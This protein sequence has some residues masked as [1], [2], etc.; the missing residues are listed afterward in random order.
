MPDGD[1]VM[2]IEEV[3][4]Y[5][6]RIIDD[7][8]GDEWKDL[9]YYLGS[10][11]FGTLYYDL[12]EIPWDGSDKETMHAIHRN[13]GVAASMKQ[14]FGYMKR[15]FCDWVRDELGNIQYN[16]GG[17]LPN[18]LK[19]AYVAEV[20][21]RGDGFLN[22]NYTKTLEKVYGIE[23]AMICHVH[24]KVG[25]DYDDIFF[26][27]GDRS[28]VPETINSIGADLFLGDLKRDLRKDT[29][30]ALNRHRDFFNKVNTD[31]QTIHSFGFSFSDVDMIYIEE[32]ANRVDKNRAIWYL[33]NH[34]AN[35]KPDLKVKDWK[36]K[37]QKLEEIGFNV[38]VDNR[39]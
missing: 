6:T 15:L 5:L 21:N 23:P 24:G 13:E 32:I 9:E 17:L 22:F 3:A 28:G 2:D 38:Q 7:C 1:E 30:K 29:D 25:D 27:H 10:S 37:R 35:E 11:I 18:M 16:S 39:W 12:E 26:G 4:G 19:K 36:S 8:G 33:N 34:D 31:V 14:A 20:L